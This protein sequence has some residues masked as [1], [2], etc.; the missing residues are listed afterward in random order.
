MQNDI[1]KKWIYFA[2]QDLNFAKSGLK[3][4]FYSHVCFLSQQTVEKACVMPD[5]FFYEFRPELFIDRSTLF[6]KLFLI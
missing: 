1:F 3:D 6:G 2:E 5:R 4:K